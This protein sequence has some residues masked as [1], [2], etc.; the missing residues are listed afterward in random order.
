M[1]FNRSIASGSALGNK[2]S[3]GFPLKCWSCL[4]KSVGDDDDGDDN[5]G[6]V[7]AVAVFAPADDVAVNVVVPVVA[8]PAGVIATAV[9][10]GTVVAASE[11]SFGVP[12]TS[13]IT[14]N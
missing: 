13:R 2:D 1:S 9:A 10:G 7:V 11:G 12:I 14:L 5:E 6:V 3:N 8:V 4:R